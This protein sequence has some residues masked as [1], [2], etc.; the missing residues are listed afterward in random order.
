MLQNRGGAAAAR[1]FGAEGRFCYGAA[2]RWAA[3]GMAP[4]FGPTS[5]D[6]WLLEIKTVS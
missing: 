6:R 4:D 2:T 1:R 3:R 5:G